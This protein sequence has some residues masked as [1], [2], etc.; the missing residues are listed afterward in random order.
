MKAICG[1]TSKNSARVQP[2]VSK[3][4][5]EKF[6]DLVKEGRIS[7]AVFDEKLAKTKGHESL[8]HR[9]PIMR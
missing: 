2:F 7:Q 1:T 8:P 6:K 4:H 5:I 3:A 9:L